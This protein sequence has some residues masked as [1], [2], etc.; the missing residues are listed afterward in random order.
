MRP[1]TS[2]K[3]VVTVPSDAYLKKIKRI[4]KRSKKKHPPRDCWW[5]DD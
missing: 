1:S 4:A 2:V 5:N 3:K